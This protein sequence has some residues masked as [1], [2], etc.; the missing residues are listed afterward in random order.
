M[1]GDRMNEVAGWK[2]PAKVPPIEPR[3]EYR[4]GPVGFASNVLGVTTLWS[5]QRA[6]VLKA[7][8]TH[9]RVAV[10]SGN[11][12]GKGFSAAVA[13][14]W[15]LSCYD[16]AVVLTMGKLSLHRGRSPKLP[17]GPLA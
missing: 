11:G 5:K 3:A 13:I 7:L 15:F 8:K 17:T 14:L 9:Q 2:R 1:P 16:Q 6:E 12:L 4:A 10:K